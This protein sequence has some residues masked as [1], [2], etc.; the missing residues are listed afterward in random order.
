MWEEGERALRWPSGKFASPEDIAAVMAWSSS[1]CESVRGPATVA[2]IHGAAEEFIRA[3]ATPEKLAEIERQQ[4]NYPGK[5]MR[6][7]AEDMARLNVR[8][9]CESVDQL[10]VTKA[11]RRQTS[12]RSKKRNRTTALKSDAILSIMNCGY[13]SVDDMAPPQ[14]PLPPPAPTGKRARLSRQ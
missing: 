4:D 1:G 9:G 11:R 14:A 12:N 10:I 2:E 3:S 5:A 6:R 7:F 13:P 8:T